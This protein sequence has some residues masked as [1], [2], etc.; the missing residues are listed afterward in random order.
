MKKDEKLKKHERLAMTKKARIAVIGA[1]WWATEYHIPFLK[2]RQSDVDLVAVCRLGLDELE[3]V[4][5][6][7]DIPFASESFLEVIEKTKPDGVIVSSPHVAHFEHA[8]AALEAGAHVLIEK[9]MTVKAED[10]RKLE[11]IAREK[12]VQLLIPHGWNFTHYMTA[13]AKWFANGQIGELRH[14]N[15]QMGSALMDLFAGKPMEE[16]A[17]HT[18][19]PP[20]STWADPKRAGGYGWGQLSHA[21]GAFFRVTSLDASTVYAK[22]GKSPTG[23]DYFDAVLMEMENGAIG[24]VSGTAAVP[25]HIGP[26]VDMRLYGDEGSIHL[27]LERELLELRRFDGKDQIHPFATGEGAKAYSTKEPLDRFVDICL[28]KVATNDGDGTVGRRTIEVLE[29]M[30]Q[31]S[32]QQSEINIKEQK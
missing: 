12:G 4:K 8:L 1:G 23:V 17:E 13:A 25:K 24:V 7:F 30:Y 19:R 3:H 6:R 16:T 9:P 5:Q 14:F 26:H 10:A 21:L 20:A 29:A 2:A 27:D 15:L 32:E 22:T 31:S 11:T 28:G 18:F